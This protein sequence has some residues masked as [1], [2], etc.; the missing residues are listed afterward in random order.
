MKRF[1]ARKQVLQALKEKG[2]YRETKDNPMVVPMCSR[3]KDIIE[4]LLKPQ[5]Y[6]N[7][8]NMAARAV[9]VGK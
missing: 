2:L 1:E 8:T 4:P 5:W 3:S 7:C 9:E 6:V